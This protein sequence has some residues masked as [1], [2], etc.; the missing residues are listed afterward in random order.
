MIWQPIHS[1]Q[2][3]VVIQIH[4]NDPGQRQ[5]DR[6]RVSTGGSSGGPGGP[7]TSGPS[8]AGQPAS[9]VP[10]IAGALPSTALGPRAPIM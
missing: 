8:D 1:E 5:E 6:G 4:W 2:L 9:S 3:L 10:Y 7:E